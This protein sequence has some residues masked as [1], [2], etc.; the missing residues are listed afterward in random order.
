M[1]LGGC[2]DICVWDPA[3]NSTVFVKPPPLKQPRVQAQI[4]AQKACTWDALRACGSK[5]VR[6][7]RLRACLPPCVS[8]SLPPCLPACL[9]P[10]LPASL[11]SCVPD[12]LHPC[13]PTSLPPCLPACPPAHLCVGMPVCLLGCGRSCGETLWSMTNCGETNWTMTNHVRSNDVRS[14]QWSIGG[15]SLDP[16]VYNHH[17]VTTILFRPCVSLNVKLFKRH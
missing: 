11:S 4:A 13:V 9:P 12:S 1:H 17:F 6:P 5:S 7:A 8:A 14:A 15:Y 16:G 10:C 3:C 2:C